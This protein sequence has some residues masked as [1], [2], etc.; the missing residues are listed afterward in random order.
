MGSKNRDV[1]KVGPASSNDP[2][3]PDVTGDIE[4]DSEGETIDYDEM[5]RKF[6][7]A[8]KAWDRDIENH[9]DPSA[10]SGDDYGFLANP[11]GTIYAYDNDGG[12]EVQ[13]DFYYDPAH[14][15]WGD[16]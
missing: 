10:P 11:N 7:K 12:G 5:K 15:E 4:D 9:G 16:T 2:K 1:S 8:A 6:P 13:A 14:D 3:P